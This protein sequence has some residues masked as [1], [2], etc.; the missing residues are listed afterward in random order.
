M[1]ITLQTSRKIFHDNKKQTTINIK[2][3]SSAVIIRPAAQVGSYVHKNSYN[4]LP[5]RTIFFKVDKDKR[6]F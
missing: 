2:Q 4:A 5:E 3:Y 6:N 1:T